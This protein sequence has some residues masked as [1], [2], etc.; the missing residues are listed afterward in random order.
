MGEEAA[1]KMVWIRDV[2]HAI[3]NHIHTLFCIT[4]PTSVSERLWG[5]KLILL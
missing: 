5:D 3:K 2:A 1:H 4:A